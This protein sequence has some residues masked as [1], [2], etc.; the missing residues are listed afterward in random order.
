MFGADIT[1]DFVGSQSFLVLCMIFAFIEQDTGSR[2][3]LMLCCLEAKGVVSYRLL[4]LFL[5]AISSRNDLS[6]Y[7]SDFCGDTAVSLLPSPSLQSK[8]FI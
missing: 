5:F 7:F 2:T 4:A 3:T 1:K 6:F 8:C